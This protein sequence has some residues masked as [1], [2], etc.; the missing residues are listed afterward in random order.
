MLRAGLTIAL[1]LVASRADA[2]EIGTRTS[3]GG[4]ELEVA[5]QLFTRARGRRPDGGDTA[6][7]SELSRARLKTTFRY[8]PWFRI[9]IEPDFGGGAADPADVYLQVAPVETFDVRIG[10]AK[11]P[12]GMLELL[13]RWRMPSLTRGMVSDVVS[14]R[15]GFGRRKFGARARWR[16]KSLP[17]KPSV[18]VGSYGELEGEVTTDLVARLA[19]R[20]TKGLDVSVMGYSKADV[21]ADGGRGQVGALYAEYER[22]RW[23]LGAE[24][25]LGRARLLSASGA[26]TNV[27][28]TFFAA[29]VLAARRFAFGDF[30][31]EPFLGAD[32]F[33]P[34]QKTADDL[35]VAYRLGANGYWME[36]FRLGV[37]WGRQTG[38][39]G[40][41]VVPRSALTVLAGMSLE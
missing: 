31:V 10:Q 16:D 7:D 33:D 13:G 17:L 30:L 41:V 29:R 36:R 24:V 22:K 1:M 23:Y 21:R 25:Q 3:T 28:A 4:F 8:G 20:P 15:L 18:E 37:E 9:D 34:N 26:A 32:L 11:V 40:S 27:D 6:W 19:V 39:F 12:F 35:G 5:G 14:D 38:Q 2:F